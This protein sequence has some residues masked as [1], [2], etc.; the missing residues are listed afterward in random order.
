MRKKLNFEKKA[1]QI[2]LTMSY[3]DFVFR[4]IFNSNFQHCRSHCY[5]NRFDILTTKFLSRKHKKTSNKLRKQAKSTK[6]G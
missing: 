1:A 5:R 2:K 3:C 4:I 6:F